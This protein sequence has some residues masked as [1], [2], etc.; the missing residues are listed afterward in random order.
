MSCQGLLLAVLESAGPRHRLH[1]GVS[2]HHHFVVLSPAEHVGW[3]FGEL[4]IAFE[5]VVYLAL[6]RVVLVAGGEAAAEVETSHCDEV[7]VGAAEA[8]EL[9]EFGVENVLAV[10]T[11]LNSVIN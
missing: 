10:A 4:D 5:E 1:C 9:F 11:V 3:H 6:D 8:G 7:F 2:L